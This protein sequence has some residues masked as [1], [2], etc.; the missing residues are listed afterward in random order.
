MHRPDGFRLSPQQARLM[1]I[2]RSRSC[3]PRRATIHTHLGGGVWQSAIAFAI[4]AVVRRH[5]I[6][7]TRFEEATGS[8]DT[9]QVIDAEARVDLLCIDLRGLDDELGTATLRRLLANEAA[10]PLARTRAGLRALLISTSENSHTLVITA[11]S[12]C[13]DET[14]LARILEQIG[15]AYEARCRQQPAPPL[16]PLQYADVATWLREIAEGPPN[17]PRAS[18]WLESLNAHASEF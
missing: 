1:D 5:E 6:L 7:R 17:G 3:W 16:A 8:G 12:L 14:S 9:V 10:R 18:S 11:L 2:W 15:D 4:H 13:A